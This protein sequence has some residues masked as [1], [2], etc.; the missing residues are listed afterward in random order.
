M[1]RIVWG[2]IAGLCGLLAACSGSA[3]EGQRSAAPDFETWVRSF[4][5]VGLPLDTA[6]LYRVHNSPVVGGRIDT[7]AV[8]AYI[9]PTYRLAVGDPVYDGYAYGVRLPQGP[10]YEAVLVYESWGQ[11]QYFVLRTYSL[12][13]EL[14]EA[15]RFSGDSASL[16]RWMGRIDADRVVTVTSWTPYVGAADERAGLVRR[17]YV[18]DTLGAIRPLEGE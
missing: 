14:V 10:G 13:G 7:A 4:E 1:K 2:C 16:R 18:L 3:S 9:D 8:Q 12:A 6:L 17:Q 5:A 15:L 11:E